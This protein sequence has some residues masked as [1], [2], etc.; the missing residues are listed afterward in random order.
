MS[1]RINGHE[2][3]FGKNKNVDLAQSVVGLE[4]G[5]EIF[6][7]SGN[8]MTQDLAKSKFNE[9]VDKFNE[10]LDEHEKLLEQYQKQLVS[11]LNQLEICPLYDNLL[12]KPFASNPFQRIVKNEYGLITDVGGLVPEYKSNEDGEFHEE[13]AFVQVGTVI[14][15]GPACKYIKAGDIVFYTKPTALPIPFYKQGLVKNN[16]RNISAVV[17]VGLTER[18]KNEQNND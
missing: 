4:S 7:M 14:E 9:Q 18:F 17:N 5:A 16:E 2:V 13:E 8:S 6:D 1:E 12:I 3:N 15:A 10:K 11:D